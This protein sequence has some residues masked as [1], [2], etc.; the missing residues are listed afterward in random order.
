ML[1]LQPLKGIG[2][3]LKQK[4]KLTKILKWLV[5]AAIAVL[6]LYLSFR[7][8]KWDEFFNGLKECRFWLVLLSMLASV[9]AF[10]LRAARWREIM[11]PLNKDIRFGETFDGINIGNISNFAFPRAGEFVRC[12]VISAKGK[13]RYDKVLGTVVLERSWD[14]L[15]LVAILAAFLLI[16]WKEFGDFAVRQMWNPLSESLSFSLWWIVAAAITVCAAA[17]FIIYKTRNTSR[18]SRKI[19]SIIKGGLQGFTSAFKMEKKWKFLL[20]TATIWVIYW[21]MSYLTMLSLPKLETLNATDAMFLMLVG[22]IAWVIPVPGGFGSFHI[23]VS[24]ALTTI[25]SIE[26]NEGLAFATLSHE[27]QALTMILCGVI[28]IIRIA[29]S[30]AHRSYQRPSQNP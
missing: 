18:I 26:Y 4:T 20:Y 30:N 15:T 25:Y 8:V 27:A 22:S 14:I 23:L 5:S 13:L 7:S 10:F 6:L 29:R 19:C 17:V 11:K 3:T 28:S 9:A 24:L 21:L 12:G 16:K 1:T 2:M